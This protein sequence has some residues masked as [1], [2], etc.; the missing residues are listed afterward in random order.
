MSAEKNAQGIYFITSFNYASGENKLRTALKKQLEKDG[1]N[2]SMVRYLVGHKNTAIS[3]TSLVKCPDGIKTY[4]DWSKVNNI[5]TK[6]EYAC[7]AVYYG[8]FDS[9]QRLERIIELDRDKLFK[10]FEEKA[11]NKYRSDR[12]GIPIDNEELKKLM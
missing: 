12:V 2:I 11:K 6:P 9:E 10:R 7:D 5:N 3:F 1:I 4:T 8:I